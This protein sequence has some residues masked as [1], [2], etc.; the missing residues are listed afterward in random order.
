MI[1]LH[2]VSGLT[3]ELTLGDSEQAFTGTGV[4]W[5]IS[6]VSL[7]ANCLGVSRTISAQYH[8]HLQQGLEMPISF[9]P[10]VGTMNV[11]TNASCSLS[12]ARSLSHLKQLYFVI[13]SIETSKKSVKDF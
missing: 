1:P 5:D 6:D 2:L 8:N 11:I 4:N 3:V 9:T 12:L 7:I 10:V 13:V